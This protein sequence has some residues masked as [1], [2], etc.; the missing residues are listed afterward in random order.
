MRTEQFISGT[1]S[2]T[3][4]YPNTMNICMYRVMLAY[5]HTCTN[6]TVQHSNGRR[7]VHHT[8][9][10]IRYWH[11]SWRDDKFPLSEFVK[12]E[13]A[14]TTQTFCTTINPRN[15]CKTAVEPVC[16]YTAPVYFHYT[17]TLALKVNAECRCYAPPSRRRLAW[18]HR[19]VIS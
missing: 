8:F 17:N 14:S 1:C 13:M 7:R 18:A 12:K 11:W 6:V 9:K 19:W 4:M 16:I 10:V 15:A 3:W 5:S 2:K